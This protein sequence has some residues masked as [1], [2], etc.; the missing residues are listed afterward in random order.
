MS[1][2]VRPT[3]KSAPSLSTPRHVAGVEPAVRVDRPRR[4]FRIPVVAAH[5]VGS[6]H[7][8][9]A[10]LAGRHGAALRIDDADLDAGNRGAYRAIAAR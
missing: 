6:A 4:Q 2:F 3:M 9:L 7:P 8:Q 10:G 5:H 1:S